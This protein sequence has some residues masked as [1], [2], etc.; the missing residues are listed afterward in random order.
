MLKV[1]LSAFY[2]HQ[3]QF[4][5][6]KLTFMKLQIFHLLLVSR[7]SQRPLMLTSDNL[8]KSRTFWSSAV[9]SSATRQF[10]RQNWHFWP[11][12]MVNNCKCYSMCGKWQNSR[13]LVPCRRNYFSLLRMVQ[14][15]LKG[16]KRVLLIRSLL[17]CPGLCKSV[18]WDIQE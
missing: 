2:N 4:Y 7:Q 16:S 3:Y 11:K 13:A 14:K 15:D 1:I 12:F 5:T 18:F 6:Y 8:R 10:W 9:S 17:V